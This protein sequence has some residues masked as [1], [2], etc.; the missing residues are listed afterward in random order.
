MKSNSKICKRP[1]LL[2]Y[3]D[4]FYRP[5]GITQKVFRMTVRKLKEFTLEHRR[6]TLFIPP[7]ESPFL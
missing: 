6:D 2:P 1:N 7:Y 5:S 3:T 4:N